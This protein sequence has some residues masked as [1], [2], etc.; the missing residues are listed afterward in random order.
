MKNSLLI[1]LLRNPSSAIGLI[2]IIL[3]F[4]AALLGIFSWLPY[5]PIEQHVQDRMQAPN[6]Q[7]LM[8]TDEFGRD[9]FSRI[10]RG[11][12]NS[13]KV[14][15]ISVTLASV[16]GIMLGSIAGYVG[17]NFDNILMR[18]MDMFFAFPAI[19]LALAIVAALGTGTRN[20]IL[21]ISIVYMP[22]F[23]RVARGPTLTIKSMEYVS[24]AHSVGARHFYI[25]RKHIF[26]NITAPLIVQI[27][28][29]LSWAILTEA[30]LSFLGLGAQPP[31]PSWGNMLSDSRTLM[32]LAPWMAIFPGLAIMACVL[33]FNL[34]GDGLRDLLDPRLRM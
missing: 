26:P 13:L 29:A 25:L 12:T 28:L 19:L 7:Y 23:A 22:I 33:G 8:G 30:G 5:S 14:G 1:R 15:I 17:G 6:Q 21:A 10:L 3:Y 16:V 24:V 4:T 32:E 27:S 18:V 11:A 2:L 20:T 9:I 34:L 31:D